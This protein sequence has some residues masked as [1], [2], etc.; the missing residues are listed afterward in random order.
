MEKRVDTDGKNFERNEKICTQLRGL[1][2]I[3]ATTRDIFKKLGNE[4]HH[5]VAMLVAKEAEL[6]N[7]GSRAA[8]KQDT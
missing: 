7:T 5:A 3:F 4:Y 1:F 8:Q 2:A 6:K